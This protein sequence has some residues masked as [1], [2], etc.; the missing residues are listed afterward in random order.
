[1]TAFNR[2]DHSVN[3][4]LR[5]AL[6]YYRRFPRSRKGAQALVAALADYRAA[7]GALPLRGLEWPRRGPISPKA[8]SG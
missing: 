8:R 3:V 7:G 1:M 4:E 6:A 5:L 2:E